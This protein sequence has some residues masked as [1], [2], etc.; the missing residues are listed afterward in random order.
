MPKRTT[1]KSGLDQLRE[2]AHRDWEEN[3]FSNTE[4]LLPVNISFN[5][6]TSTDDQ[7]ARMTSLLAAMEKGYTEKQV[8]LASEWYLRVR[9]SLITKL[10]RAA[11]VAARTN[12]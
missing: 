10:Y 7:K 5:A 4:E 8:R 9:K 1:V 2:T 6:K 12:Q 3:A 11:H